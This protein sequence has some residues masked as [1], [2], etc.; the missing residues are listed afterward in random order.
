[1]GDARVKLKLTGLNK[2]MTSPPVQAEVARRAQRMAREAGDGFEASIK[3]HRY[4]ARAYVQTKPESDGP[5][6]QA[7]EH[8]LQR[9]LGSQS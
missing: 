8:V 1:M 2:L 5:R 7:E 3:P 6:R 4:T 9:V